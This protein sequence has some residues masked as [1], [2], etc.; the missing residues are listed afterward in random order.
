MLG[1]T[2]EAADAYQK[3]LMNPLSQG[4]VD[5]Q[6]VQWKALDLPEVELVAD[7]TAEPETEEA[8]EVDA[9]EPEDAE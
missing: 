1:R 6:L 3:V 4:A 5:Q 9:T 2:A 7:E 8:V